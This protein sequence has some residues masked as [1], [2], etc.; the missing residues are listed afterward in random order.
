LLQK[1]DYFDFAASRAYYTM[2]Y[3]AEALLLDK[4]LHFSKHSAVI[5]AFGQHFEKSGTES[6]EMHHYLIAAQDRRN[7]GDYDTGVQ[8]RNCL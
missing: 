3:A 7:I 4:G 8:S 2:F 1:N 6:A 5:A